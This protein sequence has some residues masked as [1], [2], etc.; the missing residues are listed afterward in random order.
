MYLFFFPRRLTEKR[1]YENA[2]TRRNGTFLLGR[3]YIFEGNVGQFAAE[4]ESEGINRTACS[5]EAFV[6]RRKS[7]F[8]G[9]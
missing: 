2:I 9:V 8:N 1:K 4:R 7:V 5:T 3:N 6:P